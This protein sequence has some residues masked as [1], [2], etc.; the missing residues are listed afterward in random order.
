MLQKRFDVGHGT[1]KQQIKEELAE[2]KQ[3]K[4]MSVAEYFGKFQPLWDELAEYNPLPAYL[5]GN[6]RSTLLAQDPLPSLDRAY[7][8]LKNQERLNAK[9]DVAHTPEEVMVMA[10]PTSSRKL[11]TKAPIVSSFCHRTGHV[12]A[13]CGRSGASAGGQLSGG[14]ADRGGRGSGAAPTVH[15]VQGGPVLGHDSSLGT[16][17]TGDVSKVVEERISGL[18]E[19]NNFL[20]LLGNSDMS[21]IDRLNGKSSVSSWII[22]TGASTHVTGN[23]DIIDDVK[24]ILNCN[25]GLPNGTK[26]PSKFSGS[27]SLSSHLMLRYFL[28]VPQLTCNLMY[29]SQL[30]KDLDCLVHFDK[31]CC[32]IQDHR[33]RMMIGVRECRDGLYYFG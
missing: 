26:A 20:Q 6:T 12:A 19:W 25:V 14:S 22:D 27:S 2:Y 9:T 17:Q 1:R 10:I 23:L 29:V 5:F 32:L 4:T 7:Q 31:N 30:T 15:A 16:R 13:T 11:T 28:F 18:S 33:S 3:S 21:S 8:T 24:S